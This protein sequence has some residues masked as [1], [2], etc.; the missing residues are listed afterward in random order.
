MHRAVGENSP[1]KQPVFHN[2]CICHK[3]VQ[4]R[5]SEQTQQCCR[6]C[7]FMRKWTITHLSQE[8]QLCFSDCF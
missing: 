6:I 5:R 2:I 4:V 3:H 8:E 7:L 1:K